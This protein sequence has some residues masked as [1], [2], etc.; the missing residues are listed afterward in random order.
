MRDRIRGLLETVIT[1][2][3][4]RHDISKRDGTP[5]ERVKSL[6]QTL[7]RRLEDEEQP[8]SES[9]GEARQLQC[10][11]EDLFFAMQLYSYRGDYLVDDPSI[12]R[13]AETVDKFEEDVL[14]LDYPSVRGSRRVEIR[15][16]EP[17]ELETANV[18]RSAAELT[19]VMQD[20]VQ[21]LIDELNAQ[22][23]S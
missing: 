4:A 21:L 9:N 1:R 13:L 2:L 15:F 18:R 17:I 12:E 3:E 8:P 6:R 19:Q 14:G 11:M 10:D 7:I 20:R 16:G 22:S 23:S 5:P